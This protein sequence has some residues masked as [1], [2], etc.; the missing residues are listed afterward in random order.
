MKLQMLACVCH[1]SYR[2]LSACLEVRIKS[3]FKRLSH[4]T[5]LLNIRFMGSEVSVAFSWTRIRKEA[6]ALF[7][8]RFSVHI[9]ANGTGWMSLK[10]SIFQLPR[11][12][13]DVVTTI[14]LLLYLFIKTESSVDRWERPGT[15]MQQTS[16][17]IHCIQFVYKLDQFHS[18]SESYEISV[19]LKY[20]HLQSRSYTT[21][22][23][24]LNFQDDWEG[25]LYFSFVPYWRYYP[26]NTR[27][28]PL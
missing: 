4:P 14:I 6:P 25:E 1:S 2:M 19:R 26:Q 27:K 11:R 17:V 10:V 18:H 23:I 21:D 15:I 9:P 5:A 3:Y 12:T 13:P 24:K 22:K 16:H 8:V 7:V 28:T 20:E